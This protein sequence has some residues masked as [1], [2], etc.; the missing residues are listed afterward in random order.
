MKKCPYCAE[1]IQDKAIFCR[2]CGSWLEEESPKIQNKI[3]CPFCAEK[4][5][6]DATVCKYCDRKIKALPTTRSMSNT[7]SPGPNQL[8][9]PRSIDGKIKLALIL[10]G[11]IALGL[12]FIPLIFPDIDS[13]PPGEILLLGL[14]FFV[15]GLISWALV[16]FGNI[17]FTGRGGCCYFFPLLGIIIMIYGLIKL[18]FP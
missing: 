14:G 6:Y 13:G 10:V 9:K 8:D 17:E 5:D 1:E 7:E 3:N 18:F 2:F 12:I 4:I 15:V 16:W 11:V